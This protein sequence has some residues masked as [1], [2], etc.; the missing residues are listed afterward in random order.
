MPDLQRMAKSADANHCDV[1]VVG[2][3]I[4]GL[5]AARALRASDQS[6]LVLEKSRGFGGRAATR[7]WEE[8]PFDH[9]AQFFTARSAEFRTQVDDWLGRGV[10]FEW[11]RGFH[12]ATEDGSKPQASSS[13]YSGGK[14]SGM[15]ANI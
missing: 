2:G 11:S 7:R 13:A 4:A 1:L 15:V 9:G 5:T 10:C 14:K 6:V 8:M 12:R 3:G